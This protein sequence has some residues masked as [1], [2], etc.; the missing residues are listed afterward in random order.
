MSA[1][2][3][4]PTRRGSTPGLTGAQPLD[5]PLPQ[6]SPSPLPL[7]SPPDYVRLNPCTWQGA[8]P[9]SREGAT[10]LGISLEPDEHDI[11]P[12]YILELGRTANSIRGCVLVSPRTA[13]DSQLPMLGTNFKY[14]ELI[15][16]ADSGEVD[17]DT[18]YVGSAAKWVIMA[19]DFEKGSEELIPGLFGRLNRTHVHTIIRNTLVCIMQIKREKRDVTCIASSVFRKLA[20]QANR[21]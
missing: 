12:L 10:E 9:L 11:H 19:P 4:V 8:W 2:C 1:G 6:P 15:L 3:S 5:S 17:V 20:K 13:F 18:S 14:N 16:D 7:I 21:R